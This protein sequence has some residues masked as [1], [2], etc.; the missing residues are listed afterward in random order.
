M[1]PDDPRAGNP[2]EELK[3]VMNAVLTAVRS[4]NQQNN[5]PIGT[6]GFWTDTLRINRMEVL[7]AG[8][9]IR[10]LYEAQYSPTMF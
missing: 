4:Y 6:V 9:I 1:K 5:Y 8:E 7:T 3:L 10:S 2:T